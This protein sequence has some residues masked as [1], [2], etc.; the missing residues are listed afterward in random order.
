[1]S[2]FEQHS[3]SQI[4]RPAE[5][6]F[7]RC[8]DL[9]LKVCVYGF[10]DASPRGW[11]CGQLREWPQGRGRSV[12]CATHH[13]ATLH[14]PQ[15]VVDEGLPCVL[16]HNIILAKFQRVSSRPHPSSW[17]PCT[18]S[19]RPPLHPLP[20]HFMMHPFPCAGF[21][22]AGSVQQRR[23]QQRGVLPVRPG[24]APAVLQR[25]PGHHA[26]TLRRADGSSPG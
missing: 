9:S 18:P 19:N 26:C 10:G 23:Q 8:M 11:A 15:C 13:M 17:T 1:M 6:I 5:Y 3:N 4:H 2:E 14:A 24:G 20:S 7:V 12:L 25:M 21:C 22:P 16:N